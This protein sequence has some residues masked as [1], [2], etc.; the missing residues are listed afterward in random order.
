MFNKVLLT[1]FVLQLVWTTQ[2]AA[3]E[4]TENANGA[5]NCLTNM[6]NVQIGDKKYCSK[7]AD[8]GDAPIDGKCVAKGE[9][10]GC[11]AGTCTS[12]KA[13]Y[14][15]HRGGCYQIGGEIGLLICDDTEASPT[16]GECK[17]CHDGYFKNPAAVANNKPPCI[18]CNDT[19]GDGT[20]K[21]KLGCATCDPPTTEPNTATCK[22]CL[23]GYYNSAADSVTCA[24]CDEACATCSGAGNTKCTS[25][26]EPTKYLKITDSSTGASQCVDEATCKNGGTNFPAIE[27]NTQ[28]KIC[29]LCNDVTNGGIEDCTTCAF[30]QVSDQ[31]VLTCSVCTPN[32][33][34]PNQAGTKCFTCPNTGA[35]E[36]CANCNADNICEKCSGG[37]VL[38]P[39]NLCL[40]DC[41]GLPGY[42]KDASTSKCVRCHESC[43]ECTGNA[44]QCT[45]C[46]VGKMLKYGNEGSANYG[47]CENQCVVVEGTASGTCGAC[48]AQIGGT[49]YCSKCNVA[50][51]VSINGVCKTNNV[52]SAPCAD[53][54]KAGG[55]NRCAEGYFL[56]ERGCYKTDK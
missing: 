16:Q 32:T 46:P 50:A 10:T 19:T 6:C 20:N 55:C 26:K 5:G 27:A 33:K 35:T 9:N 52:R 51:E 15:L 44:E 17:K 2:S 18:A 8:A 42:Y 54:D 48:G 49:A 7:C 11:D 3:E 40:D 12:C 31:P 34:K 25:C 30:A 39:T 13:G 36:S 14:F 1:S 4:C 38:T 53:P 22:A 47:T 28:K 23:N 56:F 43:K 37:K 24:E 29:P 41:S 45:A 21:G